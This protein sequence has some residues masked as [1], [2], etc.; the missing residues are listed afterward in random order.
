LYD[1]AAFDLTGWSASS[2]VNHM[3][4]SGAPA[5]KLLFGVAFYGHHWYVP[6]ITDNSW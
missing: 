6:G 5:D 2:A 1:V 4:S 3:I